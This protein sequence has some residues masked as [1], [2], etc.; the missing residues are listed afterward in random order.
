MQIGVLGKHRGVFQ[1]GVELGCQPT[2]DH[3]ARRPQAQKKV[4]AVQANGKRARRATPP[5]VGR[6]AAKDVDSHQ[7]ATS[8]AAG[9]CRRAVH[10]FPSQADFAVFS[11]VVGALAGDAVLIAPVSAQIPC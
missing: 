5:I 3:R 9:V 8:R 11:A 1:Y 7:D 2:R 4:R 6:L 10:Q